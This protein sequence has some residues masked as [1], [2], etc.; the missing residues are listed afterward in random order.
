MTRRSRI[1]LCFSVLLVV[2]A[3]SVVGAEPEQG[4]AAAPAEAPLVL[5]TVAGAPGDGEQALSSALAKRL[6]RVG[7]KTATSFGANVYSVEGVVTVAASKAGRKSVSIVWKVFGPD[8][9]TLG[10]VAQTEGYPWGSLS[11]KWGRAADAA[12]GAAAGEIAKLI[13]R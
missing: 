10:G 2:S 1:A 11:H 4:N 3:T 7:I 13:P 9:S 5:I 12:A 6:A 8:G